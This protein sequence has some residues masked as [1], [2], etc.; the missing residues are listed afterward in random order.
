[1]LCRFFDA[2]AGADATFAATAIVATLRHAAAA[3]AFAAF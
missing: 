1:M 2:Y 3:A